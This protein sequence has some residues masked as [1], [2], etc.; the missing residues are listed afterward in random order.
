MFMVSLRARMSRFTALK[1]DH[2]TRRII[3]STRESAP[4]PPP[5]PAGLLAWF[6]RFRVLGG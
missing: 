4:H 1:L 3:L 6:A 2:A 5:A